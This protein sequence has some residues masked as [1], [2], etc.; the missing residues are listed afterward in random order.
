MIT[1]T[2][3]VS[4]SGIL[5]GCVAVPV[6]PGYYAGPPGYYAPAP[7]YYAPS[8]YYVPSFGIGIYTGDMVN[9]FGPKGFSTDPFTGTGNVA[10]S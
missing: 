4:A 7:V 8:V 6:N 2:L 9:T 10:T 3:V 1:V 5:G